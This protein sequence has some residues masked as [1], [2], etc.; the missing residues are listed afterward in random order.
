MLRTTNKLISA[1]VYFRQKHFYIYIRS[2][3]SACAIR[4]LDVEK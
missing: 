3:S 4:S 1:V 2:S